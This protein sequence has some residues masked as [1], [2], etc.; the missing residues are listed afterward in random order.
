MPSNPAQRPTR[1]QR[2]AEAREQRKAAE[3]SATAAATR[4]RRLWQLAA[5][6]GAGAVVVIVAIAIG[7]SGG[8]STPKLET[9]HKPPGTAQVTS[10]FAGIPEHGTVLG[11]PRAPVTMHE[12]ADLKCPICRDYSLTILPTLL[13]RYVRTGKLKIDFEA[14][15]FVG[16]QFN[17]GDSGAAATFAL[18]AARQ[19]RMWPFNELFYVNQQDE[20]T[21]YVT[22]AYLRQIASGVPGLN[23]NR[24]LAQRDDPSIAAEL[25]ASN[26]RFIANDFTGTPSFT[27]GPTGGTQRP[28]DTS[29]LTLGEFTSAIDSQLT[30]TR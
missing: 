25:A 29:Q 2:R 4:R 13:T 27:L 11:D 26:R 6:V 14:Q 17:P 20:T 16:E 22:D 21:R 3:A 30:A 28:I 19:N 15:H 9:G 23:A 1:D 18:A 10:E 7:S 8:K 24:A 5:V 12:Y